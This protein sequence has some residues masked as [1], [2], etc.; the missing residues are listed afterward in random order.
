[1]T[2]PSHAADSATDRNA[3]CCGVGRI[4]A[5]SLGSACGA[6]RKTAPLCDAIRAKGVGILE[7]SKIPTPLARL[8]SQSV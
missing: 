7:R 6:C 5:V 1:M 8:A 2:D 4:S 3:A